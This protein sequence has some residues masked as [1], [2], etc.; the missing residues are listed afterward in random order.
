MMNTMCLQVLD[1]EMDNKKEGLEGET[2]QEGKRRERSQ[3]E[4]EVGE[5]KRFVE[6]ERAHLLF[7]IMS[8]QSQRGVWPIVTVY[9]FPVEPRTLMRRRTKA[10]EGIEQRVSS[11]P[12]SKV[13]K[14]RDAQSQTLNCSTRASPSRSLA[15]MNIR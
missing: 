9:K 15:T 13:S 11:T 3:L 2:K 7:L 14:G 6:C 8:G 4:L 12:R 10:S 5:R 1:G